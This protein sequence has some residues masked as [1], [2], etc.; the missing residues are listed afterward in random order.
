ML[1]YYQIFQANGSFEVL[2]GWVAVSSL[3]LLCILWNAS[4]YYMKCF[5][6]HLSL[7]EHPWS[8]IGAS[9]LSPSSSRLPVFSPGSLTHHVS[10]LKQLSPGQTK[11]C[12]AASLLVA[13]PGHP[14]CRRHL[15]ERGE[16]CGWHSA[17][18]GQLWGRV[19]EAGPGCIGQ[20]GSG[21]A[22]GTVFW[23]LWW[24]QHLIILALFGTV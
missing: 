10:A 24:Y 8:G 23:T 19:P 4:L 20:N 1:C 22:A 7:W 17:E 3:P 2:E 13:P 16:R 21:Q 9:G 6:F 5:P 12:S 15:A 14:C 18:P 11:E